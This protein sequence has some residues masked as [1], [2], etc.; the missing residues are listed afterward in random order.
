MAPLLLDRRVPRQRHP[1]IERGEGPASSTPRQPLPGR[2]Q[3]GCSAVQVGYC[4]RRGA[5]A[6][7]AGADARSCRSTRTGRYA[8]P[9]AT[10]LGRALANLAPAQHQPRVLLP[11]AAPRPSSRPGSWSRQYHRRQRRADRRKSSRARSPT[12]ARRWARSRSPASPRSRTPFEPLIAGV[13][14]VANTNRYR[15][16]SERATE[17]SSCC[18]CADELAESIE[19]EGPDSVAVVFIEPVQNSGGTFTP[20]PEYHQA[21]ARDLRRLRRPAGRGRGDLRLRPPRRVVRLPATTSGPTCHLRQ[22]RRAATRRSA[23]C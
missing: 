15:C 1:V 11:R 17:A 23:P 13:R 7:G 10:E 9:A 5:R 12:T 22:G 16:K 14:H 18:S 2:A 20:H 6:G 3:P 4:V 21:R 8:H 19:Q